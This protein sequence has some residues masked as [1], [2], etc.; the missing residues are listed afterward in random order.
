[1]LNWLTSV[2]ERFG[3]NPWCFVS[4]R[5][6]FFN[7]ISALLPAIV[8]S[9]CVGSGTTSASRP[10]DLS[11]LPVPW[12]V[13]DWIIVILSW[14]LSC[15]ETD[16]RCLQTMQ[17]TL[18]LPGFQFNEFTPLTPTPVQNKFKKI[19]V[20]FQKNPAIWGTRIVKEFL[21]P[22][23]SFKNTYKC[24]L[25]RK[26]LI[27]LKFDHIFPPSNCFIVLYTYILLPEFGM[28]CRSTPCLIFIRM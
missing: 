28:I 5:F 27:T 14:Q 4:F 15:T 7:H 3:E 19:F 24:N 10:L 6:H 20:I 25:D 26:F 23:V 18:I 22:Y 2:S 21:H 9:T 8:M 16:L 13:E 11:C 17:N 12:S 1:M